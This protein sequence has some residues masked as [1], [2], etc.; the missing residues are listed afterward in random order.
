MVGRQPGDRQRVAVDIGEAGEQVGG[1]DRVARVLG[2]RRQ[3][4]LRPGQDR[5]VVDRR[6]A[7]ALR[8]RDAAAVAVDD[9]VA[10][11]DR[12]VVVGGRREGPGAVAVVDQRAVVGRQP[13]DRQRVAVD[14]GEAGEQVGGVD[15]VARVLGPRRQR[16]LRPGQD[17]RVVDRRQAEA[18]RRR[19]AAAVAVDD[20]V[21]EADRAVVVGGRREG[22]G[23]VAVVDQ[24]AVVGRQPGDRQRVAVD[25][26][27]AG[28]QVGGVDRVARCPRSPPPASPASRSGPARR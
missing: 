15:R 8:R 18:L 27:E 10:E 1:V 12:A 16:R 14:I 4:R 3:R 6:Q 23:A 17:R 13:G 21:A 22:P 20:V 11:A 28:E 25:I 2:P 7:E 24:R 19:D 26:G 5:R 9:V